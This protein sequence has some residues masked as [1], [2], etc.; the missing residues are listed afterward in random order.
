[1][2]TENLNF[3]GTKSNMQYIVK[4]FNFFF[5]FNWNTSLLSLNCSSYCVTAVVTSKESYSA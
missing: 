4:V 2:L 1:M 3:L 5:F